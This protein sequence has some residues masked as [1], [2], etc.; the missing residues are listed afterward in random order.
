VRLVQAHFDGRTAPACDLLVVPLG[1]RGDRARLYHHPPAPAVLVH[2][3]VWRRRG[4]A[5]ARVALVLA[6]RLNLVVRSSRPDGSAG[7]LCS[8]VRPQ[9][10]APCYRPIC[11]SDS[12]RATTLPS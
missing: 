2:D 10:P 12:A 1:F 9:E 8:A 4:S 5:S 7:N 11:S 6:K 3:W